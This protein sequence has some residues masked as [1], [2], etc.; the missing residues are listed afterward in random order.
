[1]RLSLVTGPVRVV[2]HLRGMKGET[3]T[4]MDC[5]FR[6]LRWI[7][8]ANVVTARAC[9]T[10]GIA[11][12][13]LRQNSPKH[14]WA[15]TVSTALSSPCLKKLICVWLGMSVAAEPRKMF[16]KI[17]SVPRRTFWPRSVSE[18]WWKAWWSLAQ[19]CRGLPAAAYHD[20]LTWQS[21]R[22]S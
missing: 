4:A 16:Q 14:T 7:K 9:Q 1:M 8:A 17:P 10:C 2:C 12:A 3:Q 22:S 21:D 18:C 15:E 5:S 19:H 11:E 20:L 13:R 6:G